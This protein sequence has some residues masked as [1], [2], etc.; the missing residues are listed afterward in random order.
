MQVVGACLRELAILANV[1][2]RD[3]R[4]W[5]SNPAAAP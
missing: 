2:T 3:G 5:E 1:V 4:A